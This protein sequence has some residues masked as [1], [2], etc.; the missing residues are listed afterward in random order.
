MGAPFFLAMQ[1]I[2]ATLPL[3]HLMKKEDELK[4]YLN[5]WL[6]LRKTDN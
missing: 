1:S 3:N 4:F 5:V 2:K 6:I